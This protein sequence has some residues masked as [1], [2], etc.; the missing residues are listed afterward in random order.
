MRLHSDKAFRTVLRKS[1]ASSPY[2][3]RPLQSTTRTPSFVRVAS[4]S[5]MERSSRPG[6]IPPELGRSRTMVTPQPV[7]CHTYKLPSGPIETSGPRDEN[8]KGALSEFHTGYPRCLFQG[9]RCPTEGIRAWRIG[10]EGIRV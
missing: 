7:P 9:F 1:R 4:V 2:T 6:P 10:L 5:F 3:I 8:Q